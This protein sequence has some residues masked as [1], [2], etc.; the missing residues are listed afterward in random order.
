MNIRKF[1]TI[2]L[3]IVLAAGMLLTGCG[4]KTAQR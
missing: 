4:K 2:G 1:C 3:S